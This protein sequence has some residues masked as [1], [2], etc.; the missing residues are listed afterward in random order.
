MVFLEI[1]AIAYAVVQRTNSSFKK[2]Y[3]I[4][5]ID[6]CISAGVFV[7]VQRV[8]ILAQGVFVLVQGVFLLVQ[9]VFVL[10]HWD[11]GLRFWVFVLETPS[12]FHRSAQDR[13]PPMI[14]D[15]INV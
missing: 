13:T 7:L 8:F 4:F 1:Q 6:L 3:S 2:N 15:K 12:K 9:W 10:V 5:Q 14:N 11:L